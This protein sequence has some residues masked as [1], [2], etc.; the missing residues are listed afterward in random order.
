M[1]P[2]L[3]ADNPPLSKFPQLNFLAFLPLTALLIKPNPDFN[4]PPQLNFEL[5]LPPFLYLG[6]TDPGPP[7]VFSY[8]SSNLFPLKPPLRADNPPL[9]KFPQLNL[10]NLPLTAPLSNFKP[11]LNKSPQNLLGN[12]YPLKVQIFLISD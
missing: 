2:A 3:R 8:L 6:F 4:N 12:L 1:K 9:R 5:N 10:A 11:P 7:L